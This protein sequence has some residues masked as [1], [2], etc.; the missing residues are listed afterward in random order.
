MQLNF[1]PK[2]EIVLYT[3]PRKTCSICKMLEKE[4][5]LIPENQDQ[6]N[7]SRFTTN[8]PYFSSS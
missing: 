5:N 7:E 8:S 6:K 2:E 3:R 4:C 1:L